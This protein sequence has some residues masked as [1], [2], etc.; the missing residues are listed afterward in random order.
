MLHTSKILSELT[1]SSLL[2]RFLLKKLS[3][4]LGLAVVFEVALLE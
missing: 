4:F 3:R 2:W 1:P